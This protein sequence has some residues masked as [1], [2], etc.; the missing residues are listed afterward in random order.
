[1]FFGFIIIVLGPI[2]ASRLLRKLNKQIWKS[3]TINFF[4]YYIILFLLFFILIWIGG[5]FIGSR[6]VLLVGVTGSSLIVLFS[7]I[8]LLT[9]PLSF[10]FQ[11]TYKWMAS[12]KTSPET[13]LERRRFLQAGAALFPMVALG[14]TGAGVAQSF[15][16]INVPQIELKFA[17]LPDPLDGFTILHLSDLHLGFYL[18][19]NDLEN[20]LQRFDSELIDMILVTGDIADDLNQLSDSLKMIDQV[21]SSIPKFVSLGNHEYHRGINRVYKLI[22]QSPIPLLNNF[23]VRLTLRNAPVFLAGADDPVTMRRDINTFLDKSIKR[24]MQQSVPGSFNILMSHRPRALDVAGKHGVD[25]I[26]SGHTHGS[27]F[28]FNGRSL[29]EPFAKE[30]YLWGKYKKGKTQLYTSAGVGHWFPFRLGCPAEAPLIV[31][32]KIHEV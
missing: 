8:L 19:L 17:N 11:K 14:S 18:N 28:G 7:L 4:T 9:L 32:R 29:F 2:A 21:K 24:A 16:E 23:G 3:K 5:Y 30:N 15:D 20:L 12:K 31:L 10:L 6:F 26:L 27:Q 22:N 13:S 1:M 25:L